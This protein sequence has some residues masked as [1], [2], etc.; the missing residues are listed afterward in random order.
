[1]L[2]AGDV[3]TAAAW[4]V[5]VG[6]DVELARGHQILTTTQR[7]AITTPTTGYEIY[8]S[9]LGRF[10]VYN[11]TA[12]N[13]SRPFAMQA[14]RASIANNATVTF[15]SGRFTQAPIVTVTPNTKGV[16]ALYAFTGSITSASFAIEFSS[17]GTYDTNWMAVQ[18]TASS[19]NG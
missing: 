4:N 8:N 13:I 9:T 18:M 10:D 16:F 2:A 19:G 12:W 7:D 6:N 1:M 3:A 15:T 14:A 5:L 11:G 17:A